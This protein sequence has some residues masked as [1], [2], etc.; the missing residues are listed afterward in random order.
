MCLSRRANVVRSNARGQNKPFVVSIPVD[1]YLKS[2]SAVK[3]FNEF[4]EYFLATRSFIGFVHQMKISAKDPKHF[5][6]T[7]T[8]IVMKSP[9]LFFQLRSIH[10]FQ[11]YSLRNRNNQG[12]LFQE[13]IFYF[14][15]VN[16][17]S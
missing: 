13:N 17:S 7:N 12:T 9:V 10:I 4:Y 8:S 15:T 3:N 1:F 2:S 16:R 11:K 14:K 5:R 6:Y